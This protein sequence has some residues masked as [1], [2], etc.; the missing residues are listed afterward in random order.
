MR[1]RWKIR[2]SR[3]NQPVGKIR[4]AGKMPSNLKPCAT[5]RTGTDPIR[6]WTPWPYKKRGTTKDAKVPARPS[7]ATKR[8]AKKSSGKKIVVR[9]SGVQ[10]PEDSFFCPRFFCL[11]VVNPGK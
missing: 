9:E 7:A 3:Q 6:L 11:S 5:G 10:I 2:T 1:T 8:K 4:T